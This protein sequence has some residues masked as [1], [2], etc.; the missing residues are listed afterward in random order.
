MTLLKFLFSKIGCNEFFSNNST[1]IEVYYVKINSSLSKVVHHY[2]INLKIPFPETRPNFWIKP[3]VHY[4]KKSLK[5]TVIESIGLTTILFLLVPYLFNKC[6]YDKTNYFK[7]Y[8]RK[9][10][11]FSWEFSVPYYY[12][13]KWQ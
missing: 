13:R 4:F 1:F 8:N 5:C 10:I 9:R 3:T 12:D 11:L 2:F 7:S 6:L